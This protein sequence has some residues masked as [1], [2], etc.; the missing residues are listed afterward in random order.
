MELC[1]SLHFMDVLISKFLVC[2]VPTISYKNTSVTITLAHRCNRSLSMCWTVC[3]KSNIWSSGNNHMKEENYRCAVECY[4]KAIDLDLRNAVYYCNRYLRQRDSWLHTVHSL[5]SA[6]VVALRTW[7]QWN[8]HR[9][10]LWHPAG[11]QLTVNW[12]TTRRRLVTAREPS[13]LIPP[14]VKRTGGWGESDWRHA[15]FFL[16]T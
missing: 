2:I 13:G 7:K 6:P 14:T 10:W 8:E 12:E 3:E 1:S 9:V 16:S 15:A 4:T 11:R 5:L